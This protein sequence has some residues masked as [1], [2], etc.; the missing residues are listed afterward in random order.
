MAP[1]SLPEETSG[2]VDCTRSLNTSGIGG[3]SFHLQQ[4]EQSLSRTSTEPV[5]PD[6]TLMWLWFHHGFS[7]TSLAECEAGVVVATFS[8]FGAAGG[9][10]LAAVAADG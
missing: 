10:V 3:T 8:L 1:L 5:A 9:V 2:P 6:R 7:C 4:Q